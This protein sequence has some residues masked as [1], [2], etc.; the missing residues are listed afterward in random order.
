MARCRSWAKAPNI[1]IFEG[2]LLDSTCARCSGLRCPRSI[3]ALWLKLSD[4]FR[5]ML[6]ADNIFLSCGGQQAFDVLDADM[7]TPGPFRAGF[8]FAE[9]AGCKFRCWREPSFKTPI[10]R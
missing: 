10:F 5:M 4:G 8:G 6:H 2:Y 7:K 3:H 9:V 1:K